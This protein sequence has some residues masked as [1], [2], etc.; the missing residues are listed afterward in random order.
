M[1]S[2]LTVTSCPSRAT[3]MLIWPFGDNEFDTPAL[4]HYE[5]FTIFK[6]FYFIIFFL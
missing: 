2:S 6:T 4:G 5:V 1:D 3:I